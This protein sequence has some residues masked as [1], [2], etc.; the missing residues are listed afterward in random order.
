MRNDDCGC[1]KHPSHETCWPSC[2]D[3]ACRRWDVGPGRQKLPDPQASAM[4]DLVAQR[5]ADDNET[6]SDGGEL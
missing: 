2:F 3:Y 6:A 1:G 5:E 4:L